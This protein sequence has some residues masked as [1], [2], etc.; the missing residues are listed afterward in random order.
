[1]ASCSYDNWKKTETVVFDKT[2]LKAQSGAKVQ[3]MTKLPAER[4]FQTP[5]GDTVVDFGQNLTG[6]VEF[7][8][9][10]SAG[11]EVEL[12]FFEVLD[13][14]GNV[15]LDNL[16][17]A[18]ETVTYIIKDDN[19]VTFAPHFT[20]QGFQFMRLAKYP[21]EPKPE[22]FTACALHSEMEQTGTFTC[23]NPDVN[24][25]MHNILWGMKGNFLDVPTDCPQRDERLGWT[26]DAQIFCRTATYLMDTYTFYTKWLRDVAVDQTEEGGVP[27]VVP[28]ILTGKSTEDWLMKDGAHSAAAW[29]DV[30]VIMPWTLYLMY[31]DKTVIENQYESMK[32]WLGFM[33]AHAE[34]H[35]WNYKLQ[36][37]DWVAL[38]AE[39]GSYFGATPTDLTCTAYYAYSTGLFAKMAKAVGK[40]ADAENYQKL[41]EEI[42]KSYQ[43]HFFD[44][45][46][47]LIAQ[48][49]TAQ[50]VSLYF[51]LVQKESVQKVT[52]DLL[53]LLEKEHGHL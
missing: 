34:D 47:R 50:I 40:D 19:E 16:R 53:R 51:D 24:Q 27:H 8:V 28:D 7:T 21:G 42:V 45:D 22:N 3:R 2:V 9:Q 17:T 36:F 14:A 13:A 35:I 52:E 5:Q 15:Y 38:D 31:G 32:A 4:I 1:M 29:A 37:G 46:G 12:N 49:Q 41:Y 43:K 26:G 18:K 30:A 20:Y 23:S 10:G 48:T 11:D 39:E 6:W 25:L 44:E 33:Q